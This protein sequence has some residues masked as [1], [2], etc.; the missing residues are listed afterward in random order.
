MAAVMRWGPS[1]STGYV[2][3]RCH[4]RFIPD[5][6]KKERDI[7]GTQTQLHLEHPGQVIRQRRG[8]DL[9]P[10]LGS[11]NET[12]EHLGFTVDPVSR[13]SIAP[14]LRNSPRTASVRSKSSSVLVRNWLDSQQRA[15][16]P[17]SSRGLQK[18][19]SQ[20]DAK[21]HFAPPR[22]GICC[23]S[24]AEKDLIVK[25]KNMVLLNCK[26]SGTLCLL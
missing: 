4:E 18:S 11:I 9:L 7:R 22:G 24:Q 2:M 16:T 12:Y 1:R 26:G 15:E 14:Q 6:C 17:S 19:S 13:R 3:K 23:L 25:E 20:P 21:S 5:I 10:G 8:N